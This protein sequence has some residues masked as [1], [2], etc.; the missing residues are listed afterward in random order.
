MGKVQLIEK[1]DQKL[2]EG[3]RKRRAIRSA[4][5]R[6]MRSQPRAP[7]QKGIAGRSASSVHTAPAAV[8]TAPVSPRL[9]PPRCAVNPSEDDVR[10]VR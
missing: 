4:R 5:P 1:A 3:G 6:Q 7:T 9:R 8:R 2:R 10:L